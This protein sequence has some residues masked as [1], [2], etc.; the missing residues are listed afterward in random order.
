VGSIDGVAPR[1]DRGADL[2]G[3]AD[4]LLLQVRRLGIVAYDEAAALQRDLVEQRRRGEI[5]DQLLLL[6]HPH[7]ITLGVRVRDDRSHVIVPAEALAAEGIQVVESGR[8]GDV[9]RRG[10]TTSTATSA[11]SKRP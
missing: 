4:G 2:P 7:V 5:P 1:A 9:S 8:G 11:T 6:E 3:P 10:V